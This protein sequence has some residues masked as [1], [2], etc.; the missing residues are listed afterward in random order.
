MMNM[1]K[2][3]LAKKIKLTNFSDINCVACLFTHENGTLLYIYKYKEKISHILN[4][5][6][7]EHNDQLNRNGMRLTSPVNGFTI[8]GQC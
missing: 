3:I 8:D 1:D 5:S 6:R 7:N 2:K 4:L